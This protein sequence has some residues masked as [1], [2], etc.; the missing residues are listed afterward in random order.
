MYIHYNTLN[1][2]CIVSV[3]A[4]I[5]GSVLI[6]SAQNDHFDSSPLYC[7]MHTL[8]I[9]GIIVCVRALSVPFQDFTFDK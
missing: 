3:L 2:A 1:T 9:D 7:E 6:L 8:L 4:K 5:F